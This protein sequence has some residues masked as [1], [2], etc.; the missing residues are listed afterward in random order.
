MGMDGVLRLYEVDGKAVGTMEANKVGVWCVAISPDGRRA[1]SA[2]Q[3]GKVRA[4]EL[5]GGERRWIYEAKAP[6]FAPPAV[7]GNTVY[8][9]DL[10]GVIH[11][12]GLNGDSK[13]LAMWKLDL[14]TNPATQQPGMVYG[15]PV[16]QAGRLYAATC[17]LEGE[18]ARKKT[19]VVCIGEK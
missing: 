3:D 2:G 6:L 10:A 19:V 14:A 7:A 4:F 15:G 11:A 17:N 18:H 1:L 13:G 12:I 8:A 9:G 16:V 5:E